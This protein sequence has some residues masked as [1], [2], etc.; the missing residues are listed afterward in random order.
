MLRLV[1]PA[2]LIVFALTFA[3]P[4]RRVATPAVHETFDASAA[5]QTAEPAPAAKRPVAGN[6]YASVAIDRAP[7]GHFYADALVNGAPVRFMVDTGATTIALNRAD[8][9]AAGVQFASGDFTGSGQ[10]VGGAV[11]L[12]P[13]MLDR[14]RIGAV[15]ARDVEAAVVEGEMGVSLLGQSWLRRVGSVAIEGDRMLLR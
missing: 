6:G 2:T 9:Q 5:P 7:D 3:A 4:E 11:A 15:E 13:V 10:A 14:V 8:A 12:K 1:L